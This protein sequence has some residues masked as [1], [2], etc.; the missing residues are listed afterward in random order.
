MHLCSELLD[1][2]V[3]T[4]KLMLTKILAQNIS[5]VVSESVKLIFIL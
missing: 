3:A 2:A 4:V 5:L 1:V